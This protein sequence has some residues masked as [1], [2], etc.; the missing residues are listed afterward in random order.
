MVFFIYVGGSPR[1]LALSV[2]VF[3]FSMLMQNLNFF[4]TMG[5]GDDVHAY[6]YEDIELER[7]YRRQRAK[8]ERRRNQQQAG[9]PFERAFFFTAVFILLLI[10]GAAFLFYWRPDLRQHWIVER[11]ARLE[12]RIV[13]WL[14]GGADTSRQRPRVSPSEVQKL[15]RET[16]VSEEELQRWSVAALKE[17]LRRLQRQA[18]L[19]FGFA[20][21]SETRETQ[22]LLR[23]GAVMEKAELVQA[24]LKARGGDSGLSCAVC[25][26]N[27]E[28]GETLRVLHCGH[29]FHLDCVDRWLTEQSRTCPLCSKSV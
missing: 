22:Q 15:R 20:G 27:Y 2:G 12:D 25:L 8:M 11:L 9:R 21:G 6:S 17:E 16:F 19:H 4:D 3:L 7:I 5:A 10:A 29:R 28:S 1:A 26:A 14:M 13:Q 24:V 23:S 18:D